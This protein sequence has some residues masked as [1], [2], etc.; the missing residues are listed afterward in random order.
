MTWGKNYWEL[1]KSCLGITNNLSP[2]GGDERNV[3]T[4]RREMSGSVMATILMSW[5]HPSQ[6]VTRTS[7]KY[8]LI[9]VRYKQCRLG[10]T[11]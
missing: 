11:P 9:L 3:E 6:T 8:V 4:I 7:G 2:G 10:K 5:L 1:T